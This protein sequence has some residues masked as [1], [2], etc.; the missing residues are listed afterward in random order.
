MTR[1]GIHHLTTLVLLASLAGGCTAAVG[2]R[3]V[4]RE[5]GA[6][7]SVL[8]FPAGTRDVTLRVVED[9]GLWLTDA[10]SVN[11]R[12]AGWM[13]VDTGAGFSTLDRQAARELGVTDAPPWKSWAKDGRDG[14]AADGA[15]DGAYR[16]ER[17]DVAGVSLS[18]HVIGVIDLGE[19]SKTFGRRVAGVLGG[20]VWGATPFTLDGPGRRVV[21]HRRETFRPPAHA[22]AHRLAIRPPMTKGVYLDA[23]PAAGAPAVDAKIDGVAA[24]VVLDTGS[25]VPLTLGR[26]FVAEHPRFADPG[27]PT[28]AKVAG[29]PGSR[30]LG[31]RMLVRGSAKQVEALGATFVCADGAVLAL[32]P[33]DDG[34]G[35]LNDDNG[36]IVGMP[37]LLHGTLTF[38]Y[39]RGRVWAE[40]VVRR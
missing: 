1:R 4:V 39:A 28:V 27:A 10:V 35:Y 5:D 23:N 18:N 34:G 7:L 20:D 17:L 40:W 6:T 21:L 19:V 22:S 32:R 16:I 31:G 33:G 36:G 12:P 25:G 2:R 37:F 26:R 38:D 29:A 30:G 13:V 8:R 11:G 3:P 24:P 15:P 14:A 9:R